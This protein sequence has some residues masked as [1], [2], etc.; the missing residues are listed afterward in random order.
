MI[1]S[2]VITIL[3][4]GYIALN[5]VMGIFAGL[6]GLPTTQK[7]TLAHAIFGFILVII[8]IVLFMW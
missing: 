8:A 3:L 5:G 6:K 1:S 7:Y 2:E 4:I